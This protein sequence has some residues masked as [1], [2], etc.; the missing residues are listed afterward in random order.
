[1]QNSCVPAWLNRISANYLRTQTG[2][3]RKAVQPAGS[4]VCSA[5]SVCTVVGGRLWLLAGQLAAIA[6]DAAAVGALITLDPATAG[7]SCTTGL[8]HALA[9]AFR[10]AVPRGDGKEDGSG[11]CRYHHIG[12]LHFKHSLVV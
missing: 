5:L 1:M 9:D 12:F 6:T 7:G 10:T 11:Q 4:K 3:L 2:R 8:F